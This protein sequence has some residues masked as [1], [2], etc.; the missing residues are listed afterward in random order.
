MNCRK[1]ERWL[2]ASFDRDLPAADREAL[3]GHLDRCPEC[4]KRAGEYAL[5]RGR[6][7]GDRAPEPLP[8]FWERLE[9]RMIETRSTSTAAGAALN[10]LWASAIPVSLSLIAG[11]LVATLF[12]LPSSRTADLTGPQTL[13][14]T[15]GNPIADAAP[16][17]EENQRDVRNL[18][19]LFAAD[20]RPVSGPAGKR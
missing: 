13:L 16:I 6:L 14:L 12:F 17:I 4:R 1:A 9:T 2:L 15:E 19:V 8:L 7:A 5:I 11:F 20:E 3:A 18:M 10:K